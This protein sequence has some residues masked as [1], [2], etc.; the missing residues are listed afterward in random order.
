MNKIRPLYDEHGVDAYYR[1]HAETYANPHEVQIRD[2]VSRHAHLWAGY[3]VLDLGAG[4]G[5]VTSALQAAGITDCV[6]CDPYTFDLYEQKT[7]ARCLRLG[8]MDIIKGGE[9]GQPYDLI[10][11]SFSMHLCPQKDLYSLCEALF[12]VAPMIVIITP[13]K[14]PELELLTGIELLYESVAL[15]ERGKRVTLKCYGSSTSA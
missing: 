14:R 8:F 1:D 15:T 13:H 7:G 5:E 11:A 4:G 9:L 12:R 2:L 6:G 10:I 3:R